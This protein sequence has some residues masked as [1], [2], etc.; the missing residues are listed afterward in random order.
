MACVTIFFLFVN[1]LTHVFFPVQVH[2]FHRKHFPDLLDNKQGF[3]NQK[4]KMV[5]FQKCS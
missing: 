2:I 1:S 4:S 3:C 5:M